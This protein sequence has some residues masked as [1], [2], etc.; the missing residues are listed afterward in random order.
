MKR[1][2]GL[3]SIGAKSESSLQECWAGAVN[4]GRASVVGLDRV[5]E[6]P[7]VVA[8]QGEWPG[9]PGPNAAVAKDSGWFVSHRAKLIQDVNGRVKHWKEST[10]KEVQMRRRPTD[11]GV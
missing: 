6:R 1:E 4:S 2:L 10:K 11:A 9:F 7:A 5:E 3:F 8:S